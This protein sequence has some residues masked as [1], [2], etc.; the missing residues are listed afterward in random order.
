MS[1]AMC[2]GKPLILVPTPSH[3]E[4]YNNAKK[5]LDLGVGELIEQENLTKTSLLAAVNKILDKNAYQQ[6]CD[7]LQSSFLSCDGLKTAIQIILDAA[8]RG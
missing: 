7:Q 5:A 8:K 4:Q 2:Y 6:T 1:Q 3:T